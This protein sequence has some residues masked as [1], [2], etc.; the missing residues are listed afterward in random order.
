ME[1]SSVVVYREEKSRI[2]SEEVARKEAERAENLQKIEEEKESRRIDSI[3]DSMLAEI[4]KNSKD[5]AVNDFG[6]RLF[7]MSQWERNNCQIYF[8]QNND[9]AYSRMHCEPK[10]DVDNIKPIT[11]VV[12]SKDS[13]TNIFVMYEVPYKIVCTSIDSTLELYS[14][15][16]PYLN[17]EAGEG[18]A[19]CPAQ[20]VDV[21]FV[22][23]VMNF[24]EVKGYD[25]FYTEPK[26]LEDY[27]EY[28]T[29]GYELK[30]FDL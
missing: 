1:W 2:H 11:V 5:K 29:V 22:D 30:T 15:Y 27:M 9:S 16:E 13:Q 6:R 12:A 10:V 28:S 18:V 4:E 21:S 17:N 20:I 25:D 24:D 7:D 8:E 19:Y 14:L 26:G 3:T 23:G